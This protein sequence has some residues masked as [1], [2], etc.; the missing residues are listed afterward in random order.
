M[1]LTARLPHNELHQSVA[2]AHVGAGGG[3]CGSLQYHHQRAVCRLQQQFV[4]FVARSHRG[5]GSLPAAVNQT[6]IRHTPPP[7]DMVRVSLG[8]FKW[9]GKSKALHSAKYAISLSPIRAFFLLPGLENLL[10]NDVRLKEL[11]WNASFYYAM[12]LRV[13]LCVFYC[14]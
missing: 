4:D 3:C 13:T 6:Q 10:A 7:T 11:K 9:Q 5:S 12:S 8:H 14:S 1:Y 2:A